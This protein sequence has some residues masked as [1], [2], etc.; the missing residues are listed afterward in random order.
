MSNEPTVMTKLEYMALEEIILSAKTKSQLI[1]HPKIH[2]GTPSYNKYLFNNIH[3]VYGNS[4]DLTQAYS[5]DNVFT[6]TGT[7]NFERDKTIDYLNYPLKLMAIYINRMKSFSN[8]KYKDYKVIDKTFRSY[9][10]KLIFH[11]ATKEAEELLN[12]Y[13]KG[14]IDE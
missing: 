12:L 9:V 5:R 8:A 11:E 2:T 7:V 6:P 13:N 3:K 1:K 10:I 14:A 4:L